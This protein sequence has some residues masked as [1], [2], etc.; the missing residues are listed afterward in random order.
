MNIQELKRQLMRD[1]GFKKVIY[2]CPAGH[3]TLGCGHMIKEHDPEYGMPVGTRVSE[4]QCLMYLDQDAKTAVDDCYAIY[5][6]FN[7]LPGVVKLVL[8][9]MAF[10]IG[11]S[12]LSQFVRMNEAVEQLQFNLAADE[13]VD[14]RW[15]H[16]TGD[17]SIRLVEEM[18]LGAEAIMYKGE[19][20]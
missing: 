3:P 6:N 2:I 7:V 13:M 8:A 1:E 16:Q 15:Y 11:R 14:S 20:S 12:R 9:N 10:N 18:R 4:D 19:G 5:S 17:R